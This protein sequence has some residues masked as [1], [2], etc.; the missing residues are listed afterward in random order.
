[1]MDI[2]VLVSGS[3]TNLQSIIDAVEAKEI[4]ANIKLVLS[5]NADA[6]ALVRAKKHAIPIEVISK[7]DFPIRADY[8]V[9]L[10]SVL[11]GH[12]IE[13]VV[14]AGFMRLLS[15]AMLK[16][17]PERIINIH[18][19]L[20]P[21]FPGLNVQREA[22]EHGVKFSGCTVHFVDE[23]L[24]NGPIIIQ[25]AVPVLQDDTVDT[26]KERILVEEHKIYPRAIDYISRGLVRIEGRRVFITEDAE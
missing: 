9:K 18:P 7:L 22:L 23:G 4:K 21:S 24:D 12:S 2:A 26:L 17:F 15:P 10:A 11:K 1:M 16:A 6:Y 5:D 20:L 14:L 13:L 19:S 3:G 25:A 8:D